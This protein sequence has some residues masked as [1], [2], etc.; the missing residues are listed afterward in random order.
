MGFLGKSRPTPVF[1]GDWETG[2]WQKCGARGEQPG[3][4]GLKQPMTFPMSRVPRGACVMT[5]KVLSWS[6]TLSLPCTSCLSSF[7]WA[8][9]EMVTER[10]DDP[11]ERLQSSSQRGETGERPAR[12][13]YKSHLPQSMSSGR[14]SRGQSQTELGAGSRRETARTRC[15]RGT[16]LCPWAETVAVF[17]IVHGDR[18]LAGCRTRQGG[19][20]AHSFKELPLP[21]RKFYSL[22]RHEV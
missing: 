1:L 19:Q 22:P 12:R 7:F 18:A 20:T 16:A 6:K 5:N 2:P 13:D 4:E 10:T 17:S 11:R 15:G 14:L 8:G 9:C 21:K 3:T